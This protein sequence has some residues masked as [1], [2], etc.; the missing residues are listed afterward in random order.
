MK[1]PPVSVQ[2]GN[3]ASIRTATV[4]TRHASPDNVRS[5]VERTMQE[6]HLKLLRLIAS[7]PH[8]T[9]RQFAHELGMSLGK[10]NYC[11]NA[12]IEKGWI[13]ARNFRNNKNKLSYVYLLTP[14]GIEQKA[15]ITMHFLRHKMAEYEALEKE[16]ED[17]RS[18]IEKKSAGGK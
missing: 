8:L 14:K 18:E 16:I 17:L 9:Q 2:A 10:V 4:D 13:K 5:T 11:V 6:A 3:L 12:L 15:I 1:P 7:R